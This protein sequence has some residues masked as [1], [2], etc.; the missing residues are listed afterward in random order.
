MKIM[1][2]VSLIGTVIGGWIFFVAIWLK[3]YARFKKASWFKLNLWF[4]AQF[5]CIPFALLI[6]SSTCYYWPQVFGS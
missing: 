6:I 5:F 2:I 3:L 4:A 1:M